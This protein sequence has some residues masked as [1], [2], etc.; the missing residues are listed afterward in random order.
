VFKSWYDNGVLH[1][2]ARYKNKKLSGVQEVYNT[3]GELQNTMT[4]SDGVLN[5]ESVIYFDNGNKYRVTN[6][7]DDE[8]N[9]ERKKYRKDGRLWST[10]TY[11]NSMPENN[12]KE[13][14]E[15]GELKKTPILIVN[16]KANADGGLD[17]TLSVK[18]NYKRVKYF[19]GKLM[20][21]KV[22]NEFMVT[23]LENQNRSKANITL[24]KYN[25]NI[26]IVAKVTTMADNHLF[27]TKTISW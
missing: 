27:L 2:V 12:L 14:A 26:S 24:D 17:V 22:F 21:G 16:K 3:K 13:Y 15:N 8:I 10:Q 18:G 5:G 19:S 9:G 6:Y 1:K 25:S 7:Q 11:Q 4:Y 23:M 20:D